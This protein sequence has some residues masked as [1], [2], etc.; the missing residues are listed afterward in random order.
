MGWAWTVGNEWGRLGK[1]LGVWIDVLLDRS[2]ALLLATR[3]YGWMELSMSLL[4]G[5]TRDIDV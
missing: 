2:L 4:L 3:L 5:K 1:N